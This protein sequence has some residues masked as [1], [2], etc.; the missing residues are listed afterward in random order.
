ME[1]S[2]RIWKKYGPFLL[3]ALLV[4][5][6]VP[7]LLL[8]RYDWPSADDYSYALY[9]H[10]ALSR[11]V[12]PLVGSW[13]YILRCYQGWQG[14]FSAVGLMTLTPL[15][16]SP[17]LY[18]L[19][20]LVMLAALC[21]GTFK[22]AHTLVCRALGG[23]WGQAVF[24]AAP[25][26]LLSIQFVASPKDTFYWWNGAV[27]YTFTYG[28]MLL[29]VER[30]V[31]LKLART[32]RE[33]L[34][35]VAPGTLAA[36]MVGGS[37]YVSA[38]LSV[39]LCG[40]FLLWFLWKDRRKFLPALLPTALLCVGFFISMAAPGNE[41]RQGTV[42]PPIGAADA[43]FRSI[44]Q[45]WTDVQAWFSWPVLLVFLLMIPLLWSLTEKTAFRFPLP[46]LFTLLSF[47]L[48]AAQNAPHF[49]A[50][51][52]AGPERL[53]SIVFYSFFWLTAANFW[54]WLGWARRAVLPRFAGRV[55]RT[56]LTWLAAPVLVVL[57]AAV[58]VQ[59]R[60]GGETTFAR[61][62]A[63]LTD[64][65]A[66]YYWQQQM[67]RLPLLEDPSVEDVLLEPLDVPDNLREL[68]YNG[69]VHPDPKIWLNQA[70]TRFYHKDTV[71]LDR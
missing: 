28:I 53:R 60:Y 41:V 10:E 25:L 46:P 23:T 20:P 6:L 21:A 54:Y 2:L 39:L 51:G 58:M 29:M 16:L 1:Q 35:A 61:T 66:E 68:L 62:A 37:N 34:W 71:A 64:G 15:A 22:L 19:T 42:T 36:L 50:L 33:I 57:L 32:G 65:S 48:F 9:T 18:W 30:M 52:E 17:F 12:S 26:L 44:A 43:V 69:D 67:E 56:E 70:I 31:A 55:K 14:T 27:Y 5:S 59:G 40:L 63:A 38:L 13:A 4:V 8:G 7:I 47:L 11:G 45:A 24:L 3:L 49:Y